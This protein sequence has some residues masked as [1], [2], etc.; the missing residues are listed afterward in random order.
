MSPRAAG[1]LLGCCALLW[2]AGCTSPSAERELTIVGWGG[3]SQAAH[4][5]AYW[6]SFSQQTGIPLHEDVWNG[7]IDIV[8]SK[9]RSGHPDWD[10]VQ[11]EVEE[12]ALGCAEG[13]FVPLDWEA[14]GGRASYLDM[15]V[16]ECG[17]GAMVWSEL[18]GYDGSRIHADDP[19]GEPKSW[20]D[21]WDLR[22]FPGRRGMRRSPKYTLEVALLA[23]GVSP[24]DVYALL[25]TPRGVDR[26]FRKLDQLKPAITWLTNIA[27]VPDLL[28]SGQVAMSMAT[29][30]RLLLENQEK[31]RN[32]K[33]VWDGNVYAVDFWAILAGSPFQHQAMDLVRYMKRPENEAR[34]P[35]YIATG[36]SNKNAIAALDP[37]LTRD[38]PANPDNLR[39]A[40][41]LDSRFWVQHSGDLTRR[42]EEWAL[43]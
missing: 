5:Q 40:L 43:R 23:D 41:K 19:Y 29:P 2:I 39:H 12:L 26:A 1:A 13:L 22:R 38:T 37:A 17:V 30:G 3:S 25:A 42:F 15:T 35:L 33:V 32:F 4:R 6:T 8:R 34:L 36:I 10:I 7:G 11:V 9:V 14:L 18:F 28:A 24:Q 16:H 27:E 31:G 21:F 20:A